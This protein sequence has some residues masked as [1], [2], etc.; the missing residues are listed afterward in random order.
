MVVVYID[1]IVIDSQCDKFGVWIGEGVVLGV[2]VIILF[3]CIVVLGSQFGL[4]I[5]VE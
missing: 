5:I 2:G 3:G 1:G 4:C